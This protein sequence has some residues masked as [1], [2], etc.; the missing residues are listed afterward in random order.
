MSLSLSSIVSTPAMS[1][2][3]VLVYGPAGVG[4]TTFA[5]GAPKPIC[6]QTEDGADVV[7][8]AR[9][10]L[11]DSYQAVEEA[12]GVLLNEQHEYQTVVIDSLDW[13][14]Q[15]IWRRVCE[16]HKLGSIEDAGYGKGYVFALDIWRRFLDGLDALRKR[17]GMAVV[18]IAHSHIKRFEDPAGEG[19]DRFEIKLHRKAADLCMEHADLIGFA[20]YRTSTKQIDGGFGRKITRAVGTGERVL[21]TAERPAFIAK[22]RYAIPDELPLGW[23]DLMTAITTKE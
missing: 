18:S 23:A 7:G 9:F 4:K 22:S 15:L 14:E 1:P 21:R 11:A 17:K 2:P 12:I 6:I 19:Y 16:Q 13:L 10:P 3:R 8:M 20:T 5:A